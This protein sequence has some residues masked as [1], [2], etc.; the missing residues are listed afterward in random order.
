MRRASWDD[1]APGD[2]GRHRLRAPFDPS[3]VAGRRPGL[4][5]V[6]AR[7]A[8]RD[9]R[10]RALVP[11][12]TSFA[13]AACCML[14]LTLGD[15]ASRLFGHQQRTL[16]ALAPTRIV[17]LA[18]IADPSQRLTPRT[19]RDIA[20]LPG[21]AAV[22]PRYE[23]RVQVRLG[24]GDEQTLPADGSLPGD[25]D[26][27][28][29]QLAWGSG[30]LDSRDPG[31]ILPRSL[32]QKLGGELT[33]AGPRPAVLMVRW[34]RVDRDG[35][36]HH[37][38]RE[39]PVVG[40]TAGG[41]FPFPRVRLPMVVVQRADLWS[42]GFLDDWNGELQAPQGAGRAWRALP[43]PAA[44]SVHAATLDDVEPLAAT[45]QR[46]FGFDV[47][48]QSDSVRTVRETAGALTSFVGGL[49]VPVATVVGLLILIL[50][51]VTLFARRDELHLLQVLGVP[52]CRIAFGIHGLQGLLVGTTGLGA[53]LLAF[54]VLSA[55]IRDA[56][57]GVFSVP[58][59]AIAGGPVFA[60]PWL[61][62]LCAGLSLTLSALGSILPAW[63]T[64][65]R[66]RGRVLED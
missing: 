59:D 14:L 46:R 52:R 4:L 62:V 34:S 49:V 38:D 29:A 22:V 9:L 42:R 48:S 65:W 41:D 50:Q 40:I 56:I 63:L 58:A 51:A 47:R 31:A 55:A 20:A 53:A 32:L 30:F 1:G 21:V 8:W 28:P 15:V 3:R 61:I 10:H 24:T 35:L 44:L 57:S 54:L 25:P 17:A 13:I 16:A 26:H 33:A 66:M 5:G 23:R 2:D 45:L 39:F 7:F 36:T 43:L 18:D 6:I 64:L 37:V 11:A 60:A 27:A 19:M 12:A